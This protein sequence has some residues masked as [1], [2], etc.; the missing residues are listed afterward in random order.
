M[1]GERTAVVDWRKNDNKKRCYVGTLLTLDWSNFDP[2]EWSMV[3]FHS[4]TGGM[5]VLADQ[6]TKNPV[7]VGPTSTTPPR[8]T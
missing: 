7:V 8:P 2:R 3:L 4:H 6:A 5:K 1:I